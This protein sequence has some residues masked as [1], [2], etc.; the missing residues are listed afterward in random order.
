[1]KDLLYFPGFE[2]K[3]TAWLKFA[4]LYLDELRPII[5]EMPYNENKY[6]SDTAIMVQAETKLINPYK[7]N[8]EDGIVASKIAC[9]EFDRYLA[10][11]E[12]YDPFFG[13]AKAF[14]YINHKWTNAANHTTT[15]FD[16][17]YSHVFSDYCLDNKIAT[18]C[19]EGIRL[20]EDL[21][22]VYMSFLA[23][24]I[25]KN[26]E[27][28]MITDVKRYSATLRANDIQLSHFRGQKLQVVKNHIELQL[29]TNL[30]S[31]PI[32]QIIALRKQRSFDQCRHEFLKEINKLFKAKE[33]D[34]E[35][36][37]DNYLSYQKD[38]LGICGHSFDMLASTTMFAMSACAIAND[39]GN[40]VSV[41]PAV[42]TT[43]N[44]FRATKEAAIEMPKF[45]QSLY[46]KRQ[47]RRYVAQLNNI[48]KRGR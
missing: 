14:A 19:N 26:K 1:M 5:P 44:E 34:L 20:S 18:R 43:Y 35:F 28:E 46:N 12:R 30:R 41:V 42:A 11:P 4:L 27:W 7:P 6:L 16:G 39:I 17:K 3:D 45:I 36:S 2:V 37:F 10:H 24:T 48:N 22:F 23:D 15:L 47:A 31:I 13:R 33:D 32:E 21:A 8:Y 9:D 29:P 25:A 40:L 38:F